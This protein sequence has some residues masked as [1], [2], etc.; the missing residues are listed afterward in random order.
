MRF[1]EAWAEVSAQ[2]V[3]LRVAIFSL[4]ISLLGFLWL[5]LQLTTR[6]L[7]VVEKA[8][9]TQILKE[10]PSGSRTA[11]EIEAYLREAVP[12]RF[13]TGAQ[14]KDGW[15]GLEEEAFRT[16]EQQELARKEMSQRVLINTVRAQGPTALVEAD[17]LIAVGKAKTVL[18]LVVQVSI[19][20]VRRTESNP[21]GLQITRVQAAP[22]VA[23]PETG[24]ASK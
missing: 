20:T 16:Q 8:C 17:R 23:T 7:R 2:N 10:A 3:V 5:V 4:S 6:E 22:D 12:M 14:T 9:V 24:E 15:L 11:N 19:A 21:Y 13:D 1:S 18:R